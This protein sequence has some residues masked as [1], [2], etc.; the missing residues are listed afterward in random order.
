M[1]KVEGS[2]SLWTLDPAPVSIDGTVGQLL[3]GR[4][5]STPDRP[6]VHWL[7]DDEV[8]VT[9]SYRD[10]RS[11]RHTW[12]PRY[13]LRRGRVRASPS[14]RRTHSSGSTSSTPPRSWVRLGPL[15]PAMGEHELEQILRLTAPD[16]LLGAE[17][18]RGIAVTD[19]L[20]RIA[21]RLPHPATVAPL[22]TFVAAA[23][24]AVPDTTITA[25]AAAPV[26]IQYTSGTTGRPK[27]AVI[28]HAAA[29]N[30]AINF[31][32]GWAH[33]PGD[34]LAGPLPLHHVAGRSAG[35]WPT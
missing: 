15:N 14:A 30:I 26:L 28:A 34:I 6:A 2:A 22:D 33:G 7:G 11:T 23:L 19:R 10:L 24:T 21:D 17:S 16:L 32:H 5:A 29:L 31:V 18:Y 27:G 3:A 25:D 8:L 13:G 35:C 12:R 9:R 4:A 20:Q 1:G